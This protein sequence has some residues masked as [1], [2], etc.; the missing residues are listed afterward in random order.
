MQT[1]ISLPDNTTATTLCTK[2][3][4]K[5]L[6]AY[7]VHIGEGVDATS[8]KE[9]TNLGTRAGGCLITSKTTIV[10]GTALGEPEFKTMAEHGM[11]L[12]WSPKSNMFL[13]NQTAR[14]DLALKSGVKTIALGP[15]WSLG[16]S[17]NLLDELRF[18]DKVDK[19]Q[20]G[21]ILTPERLFRMVT[22]DAARALA[23][24]SFIG[25]LEVGKRADIMV[26]NG[27]ASDPYA[28]LLAATP[29]TVQLVM[30]DGRV[31]FGEKSLEGAAPAVPGCED[32]PVCGKPKFLC[33]AEATTT[34]KLSQKFATFRDA[35]VAALEKYDKSKGGQAPLSPIA[36]LCVCSN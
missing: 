5:T 15:D 18:A 21:D 2:M 19:E 25:S 13:Y 17:V 20:Y 8:L 32:L 9:F 6:D 34:D 29:E 22:I 1:S 16:G 26:T 35:L 24:D 12:V 23:L 11:P 28:A 14:I 4:N 36:P 3:Q 27:D 10:H 30:V 31:L 7:V 33:A